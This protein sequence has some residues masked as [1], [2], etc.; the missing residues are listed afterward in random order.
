MK[1]TLFPLILLLS[2]LMIACKPDPIGGGEDDNN[3]TLPETPLVRKYLTKQ[4]LNDDPEKV[5][6]SIDWN[7]DC[8]QIKNV[9]YGTG[10]G[11]YVNYDFTYYNEDSIVVALSIVPYDG[12]FSYPIWE[13]F[14][15]KMTIHL[16]DNGIKKIY[17]YGYGELLNIEEYVYNDD[18][19]LVKR[20][21]SN[22]FAQDTF[23][24]DGDNV[25]K[26]GNRIYEEFSDYIHPHYTLPFYLSSEIAFEIRDPL[27]TPFWKNIPQNE[28]YGVEIDEDGYPS[29]RVIYKDKEIYHS[30]YYTTPNK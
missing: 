9:K 4:L 19:K 2:V 25:I 29:K 8:S 21:N 17:G 23:E 12:F 28:A 24:W 6:L 20:I 1:K 18:G 3:D 30:F 14:Y 10:N 7:E 26:W 13:L 15:D 22:G 5:I 11:D 16:T 27:L